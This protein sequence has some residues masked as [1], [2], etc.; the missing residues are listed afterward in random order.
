MKVWHPQR[1]DLRVRM[2]GGC[3]QVSHKM[4]PSLI[5]EI[6][7]VS[8]SVMATEVKSV[9]LNQRMQEMSWVKQLVE[10]HPASDG[11]PEWIKEKLI[12][13]PAEDLLQ[14]PANR[15]TWKLR[16]KEGCILHLYAGPDE[17]YT[18]RRAFREVGG[19]AKQMLELDIRRSEQHSLLDN[20]IYPS[21]LRL[22]LDGKVEAVIGGPNCRTRSVLRSYEGGPPH[23]RSWDQ[24]QIWGKWEASAED[25]KKVEEDDELMFKMIAVY[26]VAKYTRKVEQWGESKST[27]FLLEQPDAPDYKPEVVSFWWTRQWEALQSAEGLNLLRIRQ[28]DYGGQYVKPTGLGTDL[29][30]KEGTVTGKGV[31]RS[32][33]LCGDTKQLA[34]WTRKV[35]WQEHLALGHTPFGRDCRVCQEAAAKDRP[36]RRV[37]HPLAGCLSVDITGPLRRSQDQY[38]EKK[39]M[40]IGAFTWVRSKKDALPVDDQEKE[41]EEVRAAETEGEEIIFDVPGGD[42][43]EQ[44]DVPSE[45]PG[46]ELAVEESGDVLAE[47][48]GLVEDPGEEE[49]EGGTED[50]RSPGAGPGMGRRILPSGWL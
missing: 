41:D 22:A 34:R 6:E 13:L 25:Q 8:G 38:G 29:D 42:L 33:G 24:G 43:V 30:V 2:L 39:Y 32:A 4:A 31:G 7:E 3:P 1:G 11:I 35:S 37:R 28:G 26:L 20:R 23:A 9:K 12:A 5:S 47:A 16:A 19:R 17:G 18:M 14:L 10:R 49:L 15:R 44:E 46:G 21:L 40:L 48:E 27:Y 50:A 45:E 36:H